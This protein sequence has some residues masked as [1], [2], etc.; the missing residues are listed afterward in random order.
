[1]TKF[2]ILST[3]K[4]N[5]ET[6]D[7]ASLNYIAV[8]E[9]SFITTEPIKDEELKT[10]L[11]SFLQQ[12]ITAV[13]TSKNAVAA[14]DQIVNAEV[15][16]KI[17]CIGQSTRN[18]V[19]RV[20]GEEKI[21]GIADNASSLSDIILQDSEIKKVVFFC[22]KQRREEMPEKLR[23]AEIELEEIVVYETLETPQ[24]LSRKVY[25]GILFFSPSAV[26]SFFSLNKISEQTQIFAIG[27][28][29]ADAIHQHTNKD[30]I[31]AE[32]PAEDEMIE[33]V[34]AHFSTTK[35]A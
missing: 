27:K 31:I 12:N 5:Q 14:F 7:K 34:I 9:L 2:K 23:S 30:L 16:W 32:V 4:L 8:D 17:F 28:T 33:K 24:K 13:F 21:S 35:I 3:K 6:I 22:G 18:S 19:A 26:K 25:H 15:P 1:M 11:K 20:F 10:V 29:T